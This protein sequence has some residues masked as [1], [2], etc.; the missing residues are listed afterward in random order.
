MKTKTPT[1]KPGK[2]GDL[3]KPE[4]ARKRPLWI[5]LIKWGVIAAVACAA[6]G[7]ATIALVFWMYGRDP[8]LPKIDKLE[9]YHP[10]QVVAILDANDR[11][12]GELFNERR[13]LVPY[14]KIPPVVVDAFV[15]AEDR[16]FWEHGGIDYTGMARAFVANL[17]A[18]HNKEGASTITQQVVKNL[19]LTPERTFR[20]KIQEIILARR[21]EKAL[22][23][24]EILTL[25][26]NQIYL[27]RGRYGIQEA[28]RFYFGKD[29]AQLDVG[30]AAVL[31]SLPKEP[32]KLGRALVSMRTSTKVTPTMLYAKDRQKYVLGVMVE[33]GKLSPLDGQKWKDAKIQI[34]AKPFPE[35]GSSPEWI[36]LVKKEL[37]AEKGDAAVDAGGMIR[38]TMQPDLQDDA[39]RALQAGLR[40]L[41]KRHGIGRAVRSVKPDK[42]EGE[43]QKL[44]RARGKA[45]PN[46]KDV[47]EA[48]VTAVHDDAG[49]LEVDLGSWPATVKLGGDDDRRYNPPD[50]DGKVK[51]PSERFKVGDVID[52]V[53][54]AQAAAKKAGSDADDDDD[55]QPQQPA[56][57]AHGTRR[58]A[59]APGAEGAV[60]IMD[61]KTRK[62]RALVGGY[63]SRIAGFDRATMAKRQPGSSFKPIV[64]AAAYERAAQAKCHAND[65]TAKLVCATPGTIVNDAPEVFDLWRPKNFETGEYL[66]P[67]RLREALAKSINTVSIRITYDV[68][69]ETVVGMAHRLGI[70]SDL[71]NE[72]SLALGAGE[73]TP[74]ELVNAYATLASG[75]IEAEPKFID[76][77]DGKATP[78][79]KGEQVVA[80][81]IAYVITDTMRSVVTE[82]TGAAIGAKLKV[83]IAGKTGTSNEARDTWFIGMTPDYVI[84]VWIGY[85]DNRTM[86]GE[87]GAKVAAPVFLDIAKQMNLPNKPFPRPAHVVAATIDRQ[88]G[89]LAPDGAPKATTID[90]VFVEGTQPT[91]VAP[92]PGEVTEGSSV[93][94]EYGD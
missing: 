71:P 47:Y 17:R 85:D 92:R 67:V 59:F 40:V 23:K 60:V 15:A 16:R 43:L 1:P 48:L 55:A 25:Y 68:K 32:E 11:R 45:E 82:G 91:E 83:P 24:E 77:I 37:I 51:A 57:L 72:M 41:D 49:E 62:V 3:V 38:T 80:P 53:V 58:V 22:T 89:L 7:V 86:P 14:D 18:G 87:Q 50:D 34:A 8:N 61:V 78:A 35:L 28:S 46:G 44:A 65:P 6:I 33:M 66:G 94:G 76:A 19:L 21:L 73:V 64:Y 10:K 93:T 12:I 20:R 74:L 54:P 31:A 39:Q 70:K 75:G 29:V 30:E 56:K 13:T 88:T 79:S 2:K 27:G 52:V 26:L 90:E 36:D 9:D 84:G 4:L 69:P 5:T 42:L 81:E 63:A